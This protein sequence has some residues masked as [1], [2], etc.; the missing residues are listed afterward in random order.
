VLS[1]AEAMVEALASAG[2]DAAQ[3]S[4]VEAHGTGT[5]LGDPIEIAALTKAFRTFTDA[6][7]FCAIGSVKPNIGHLDAAAGVAGLIKTVLALTHQTIPASLHFAAPNPEIDFERSPFYVNASRSAWPSVSGP[8]R[9]GVNS[10][11]MGGTNAFVVVEEAPPARPTSPSRPHQL[12]LISAKTSAAL[13]AAT[14]RLADALAECA[15]PPLADVAYTLQVGRK[16]LEQRRMAVC[17]DRDA[18]VAALRTL[19]PARVRTSERPPLPRDVVFMFSGQGAQ[20]VDMGRDLYQREPVF[21]AQIDRCAALLRPHLGLDLREILYPPHA[22]EQATQQIS[23]TW[24]TQPALFTVEYALAQLWLSWGVQPAA[25]IGHSIGEYVA[26]T[27]A[28][29]FTLPDALQLVAARGRL[30]QTCPPGAMISVPLAEQALLPLLGP[31]LDLAAVN[32]AALCAVAGPAEPIAALATELAERGVVC[33]P[34]HTSH[35]FH[36][37]MMEPAMAPFAAQVARIAPGPPAI[38]LLSNVTGGWLSAEQATDPDYWASHLRHAVRF[39]DGLHALLQEPQR[40][41]LEVGPGQTL[42][43]LARLHPA[44]GADHVVL[45]SLP[46][47]GADQPD[48]AFLLDTLGQL[49]LSGF[50]IDWS[51]FYADERRQRR[52]LPTYPFQRQRYWV[53]DGAAPLY[54]GMRPARTRQAPPAAAPGARPATPAPIAAPRSSAPPVVGGARRQ[55]RTLI[56]ELVANIWQDVLD[57]P[58]ISLD[59]DFFELGGNSILVMQAITQLNETF[60]LDL[61]ALNLLESPTVASLSE[62]IESLYQPPQDAAS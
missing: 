11:G 45:R 30:M 21:T 55:G 15:E 25:L 24:L 9:A 44:R 39:A 8:R 18:A 31:G 12:L 14:S 27:L 1:Q 41:L 59:D 29:V 6:T 60:D 53:E 19:D 34:L 26:A 49:W 40:V 7:Q 32:G 51:G 52:P 56:Q 57:V 46:A 33:R 13:E 16:D 48:D 37:A 47:P 23:Q 4:Y 36:S 43:S 20:Y 28:D 2:I 38:P 22:A 54:R 58:Q 5:P 35:A 17:A 50:T 62:R 3:L 42:S 61:S 10:L